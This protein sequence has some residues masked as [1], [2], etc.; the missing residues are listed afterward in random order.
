VQGADVLRACVTAPPDAGR[1]DA[2]AQDSLAKAIGVPKSCLPLLR[3]PS[4]RHQT[5]EVL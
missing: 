4:A 5:F 3:G 1:A 2:A